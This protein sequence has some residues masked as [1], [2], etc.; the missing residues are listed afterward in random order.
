LVWLSAGGNQKSQALARYGSRGKES[1][2]G[3]VMGIARR[4][5]L[6]PARP[7]LG[8]HLKV[9]TFRTFTL[10]LTWVLIVWAF[11][12]RPEYLT[13]IQRLIQRGLEWA[14]DSIPPPWGP[15]FEFVVR[16]IGGII[17]LQITLIVVAL[18]V[19]LASLGWLWRLTRR[20]APLV[21]DNVGG[22]EF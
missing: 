13:G 18:R 16:E 15:R 5:V 11:Y 22:E 7:G 14:G 19:V 4:Q 10:V 17:W 2:G 21:S 1:D 3:W 12:Q 6:R 20:R 8:Y 9:H